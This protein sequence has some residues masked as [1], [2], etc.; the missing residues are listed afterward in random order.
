MLG[1]GIDD[2]LHPILDVREPRRSKAGA[3]RTDRRNSEIQHRLHT[4]VTE[5]DYA[6]RG[7]KE[8]LSR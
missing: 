5:H 6:P 4:L 1:A 3:D 7:I 8:A 2:A